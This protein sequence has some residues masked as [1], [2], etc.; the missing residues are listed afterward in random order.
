VDEKD[1]ELLRQID[2]AK[3]E[4]Y[5][6]LQDRSR[7]FKKIPEAFEQERL[8]R[9]SSERVISTLELAKE[10]LVRAISLEA[11]AERKLSDAI[12]KDRDNKQWAE[13]KDQ[14]ESQ[15]R[16]IL[17]SAVDEKIRIVN[18]SLSLLESLDRQQEV[19]K[20]ENSRLEKYQQELGRRQA[21]I[22]RE[23]EELE[24]SKRKA[25]QDI[26]RANR[27]LESANQEKFDAQ[28]ER[29]RSS[30]ILKSINEDHSK[31]QKSLKQAEESLIAAS[32]R[33]KQAEEIRQEA[34]RIKQLAQKDMDNALNL[35]KECESREFLLRK[36]NDYVIQK[37]GEVQ[38]L[39]RNQKLPID[40]SK[41]IQT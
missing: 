2:N 33:L 19:I 16:L 41:G 9:G 22:S 28:K 40:I 35:Q 4:V 25:L 36:K 10:R 26:A 29:E 17:K 31:Q 23:R 12:Y 3:G 15:V 20:K 34:I 24:D 21:S 39:V 18:Q 1:S 27:T 30:Q 37:W 14:I 32:D 11:V 8:W 5:A 38:Q 13:K 6:L 7:T